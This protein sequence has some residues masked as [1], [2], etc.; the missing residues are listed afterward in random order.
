MRVRFP[1]CRQTGLLGHP[2]KTKRL[3]TKKEAHAMSYFEEGSP[4]REAVVNEGSERLAQIINLQLGSFG[5]QISS[6][7]AGEQRKDFLDAFPIIAKVITTKATG[8]VNI[9]GEEAER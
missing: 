4:E 6:R 5:K 8:L 2:L 1:A 9:Q 3:F 7:L